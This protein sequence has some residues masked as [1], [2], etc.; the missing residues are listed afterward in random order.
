MITATTDV[1]AC[2]L[3][4][5]DMI[6]APARGLVKTADNG[7]LEDGSAIVLVVEVYCCVNELC[8]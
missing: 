1:N 5:E 4:K 2:A 7:L 3:D 6:H 8:N